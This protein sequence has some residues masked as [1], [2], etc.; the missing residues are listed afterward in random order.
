MPTKSL[1]AVAGAALLIALTPAT[2]SAQA[3]GDTATTTTY[4]DTERDDDRFPWGLL[5]LLGLAGLI[6]RK[7]QVHVDVDKRTNR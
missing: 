5:G 6:P 3:T 1:T 7:R 2:A 4:Q